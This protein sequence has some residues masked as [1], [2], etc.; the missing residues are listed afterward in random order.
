MATNKTKAIR[1]PIDIPFTFDN[2][3]LES[4]AAI[5][6]DLKRS[7]ASNAS[8]NNEAFTILRIKR[9]RNEEPLDTLVVEEQ[10]EK[11]Q[12]KKLMTQE[13]KEQQEAENAKAGDVALPKPSAVFRLATTVKKSSFRDPVQSIQLRDRINHLAE[14]TRR[15]RSRLSERLQD[16]ENITQKNR[17][18]LT[19]KIQR[20][21]QS[22]R[23]RVINQNR[24][25]LSSHGQLPPKVISSAEAQAE[26]VLDMFKMYDAVKEEAPKT[27]EQLM[28][29]AEESDIMCNFLPMV[30]EYLTISEQPS[31]PKIITDAT[32]ERNRSSTPLSR[33]SNDVLEGE[34]SDDEYVYDIYYRDLHADHLQE[35]QHRT[36]GSLLWFSDDENNFVH[37]D[38]SSEND[39]EDSDSNAEDYYQN[40]YPEE[41]SD[42]EYAYEHELSDTDDDD[43]LY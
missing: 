11:M 31:D 8:P 35:S 2:D 9:K 5:N 29:E 17:A 40:D 39:Y 34:E 22:A 15:P 19:E 30:R 6:N 41:L 13:D 14:T 27:K 25:G 23:Y 20:D 36:I 1:T 33:K 12:G 28:N 43:Y 16:L 21:A 37:E 4:K 18:E 32:E 3:T 42:D 38:D 7:N 24:V 26:T 10:L